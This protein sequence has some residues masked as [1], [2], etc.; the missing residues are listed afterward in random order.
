[1][2]LSIVF[3][4]LIFLVSISWLVYS[5]GKRAV[6]HISFIFLVLASYVLMVKFQG[7]LG[8]WTLAFTL[9]CYAI[10]IG[11]KRKKAGQSFWGDF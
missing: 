4:I 6:L 11:Y 2:D 5:K 3:P 7:Q 8:K 10:Y 1:M 9:T